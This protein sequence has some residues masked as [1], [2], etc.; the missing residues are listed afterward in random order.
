MTRSAREDRRAEV[1]H[2]AQNMSRYAKITTVI[3]V[4]WLIARASYAAKPGLGTVFLCFLLTVSLLASMLAGFIHVF[5]QRGRNR[6]WAAA[7]VLSSGLLIYSAPAVSHAIENTLFQ[8]T[9]PRYEGIIKQMESGIIPV[10]SELRLLPLLKDN[11]LYAVLA[12]R[13]TKGV[14]TVEF[15][16]DGAF[17]VKHWGYLYCS[18]SIEPHSLAVSRWPKRRELRPHWFRISD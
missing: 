9:L 14:L 17:P 7:A 12:Q 8:Q 13:D 16:T 1:Q 11:S 4:F 10:S 3:A 18:G 2:P 5:T 15:L 6:W